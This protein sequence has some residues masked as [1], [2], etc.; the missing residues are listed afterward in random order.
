[1]V[2]A[3]GGAMMCNIVVQRQ[4]ESAPTNLRA[5]HFSRKMLGPI[6]KT[7]Q[8]SAE[9][10]FIVFNAN[11]LAIGV[12]QDLTISVNAKGQ[13]APLS[14]FE[15]DAEIARFQMVM[16]ELYERYGQLPN[17]VQEIINQIREA[18]FGSSEFRT[19][20]QQAEV[21]ATAY[22]SQTKALNVLKH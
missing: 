18:K 9:M 5:G 14:A 13:D 22:L 1:M 17:D 12:G 16:D 2:V 4:G 8:D 6:T 21:L 7:G 20:C 10:E 3:H 11:T 15:V 19:L